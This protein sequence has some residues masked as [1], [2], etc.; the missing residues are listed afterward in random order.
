MDDCP[1]ESVEV[2]QHNPQLNTKM[3]SFVK[4]DRVRIKMTMSSYGRYTD[5]RGKEGTVTIVHYDGSLREVEMDSGPL[6][7]DVGKSAVEKLGPDSVKSEP[8]PL[9]ASLVVTIAEYQKNIE[10][11]QQDIEILDLLSVDALS[12]DQL[13]A[14]RKILALRV[15]LTM[16]NIKIITD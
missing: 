14:G 15:P 3:A 11:M 12:S 9:R 13:K 1:S 7:R 5:H 16:E 10:Q 8:A 2:T 6:L 4:G